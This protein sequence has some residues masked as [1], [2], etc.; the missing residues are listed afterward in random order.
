MRRL[1]KFDAESVRFTYTNFYLLVLFMTTD[2]CQVPV[3]ERKEYQLTY[4]DDEG[5]MSLYYDG[6]PKQ[7]LRL[8]HDGVDGQIREAYESYVAASPLSSPVN[9]HF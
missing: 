1:L 4:V 6:H 7:D 3:V 2:T 9:S 8:G 5:F